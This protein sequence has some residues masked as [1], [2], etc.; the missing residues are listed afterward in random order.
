MVHDS[1]R[2]NDRSAR[3]ARPA[4]ARRP[5]AGRR[6]PQ[7][8]PA[9]PQKVVSNASISERLGLADG[10]IER[11]TGI[12][13]R[14]VAEPQERLADPRRARGRE[15][16]ARRRRRARRTSTWCSSRRPPPTR[17]CPN[18]APLV[19]HA[20]GATRAG[21]FDIGAAC[22]GFLAGD[23]G[24]LLADRGGPRAQR[25]GRSALTSWRGSPTPTTA[26][27]P[28][29]SPTAPA[30]S[31]LQRDRRAGADRADRARRGRCRRGPHRR[32]A[33]GGADPDARPRDASSEAVDVAQPL[34]APG[35]RGRRDWASRTST[36]S[37]TT[38]PTAGSCPPSA[39]GSTCPATVSSTASPSTANT[40]AATLPL[41]LAYSAREG[42]LRRGDRVL[43]GAFG[44][45]LHVGRDRRRVGCPMRRRV[46]IT[47][48]GAVTPLGVGARSA[49]RR[50]GRRPVGHR[51]RRRRVPRVRPDRVHVDEGGAAQRSLRAARDRRER[52]RRSRRRLG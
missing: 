40:S 17:C 49:A 1:D 38:R 14:R 23:V 51:G 29:C 46:L 8:A 37:S 34:D 45:G 22:T 43:L 27:R 21:A 33:Q 35:G 39:S 20:L 41:A 36:C 31:L 25:A 2:R 7:S 13:E 15:R 44:A 47:G 11:R 30:R 18:A 52:R 6:L 26:R 19:A 50:L 16:A 24:R 42:R 48:V 4:P 12:R 9:C 32:R 10:W 5:R 3:A 28:P